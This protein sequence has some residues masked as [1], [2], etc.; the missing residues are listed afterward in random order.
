[1]GHLSGTL[2]AERLSA[3]EG[4]ELLGE[5]LSAIAEGQF[6]TN[7]IKAITSTLNG[8]AHRDPEALAWMEELFS[9]SAL[10]QTVRLA[11]AATFLHI[12]GDHLGGRASR[13]KDRADCPVEVATYVIT[14][15]RQ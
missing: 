6:G 9:Y 2:I 1:M 12:D 5:F 11:I 3:A 4:R 14:R 10:S 13:L 7:I 15:L 8:L